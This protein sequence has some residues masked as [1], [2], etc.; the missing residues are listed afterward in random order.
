[1]ML[2]RI[3]LHDFEL[4]LLRLA[5][6]HLAESHSRYNEGSMCTTAPSNL[7]ECIPDLGFRLRYSALALREGLKV[8]KLDTMPYHPCAPF[9]W[10]IQH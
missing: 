8:R 4:L 6:F 2:Q 5:G 10:P 3:Y 1:M 9:Y 7:E